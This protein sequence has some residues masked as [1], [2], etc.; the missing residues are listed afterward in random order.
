MLSSWFSKS[1]SGL[2]LS[3]S[4]WSRPELKWI[5]QQFFPSRHFTLSFI[6]D[7]C[8][9]CLVIIPY[10]T[11]SHCIGWCNNYE[12]F[13]VLEV[14]T[15]KDLRAIED[16]LLHSAQ[17]CDHN[18][19]KVQSARLPVVSMEESFRTSFYTSGEGRMQNVI[20][21]F[22]G[23]AKE[24]EM[25]VSPSSHLKL[26]AVLTASQNDNLERFTKL[27]EIKLSATKRKFQRPCYLDQLDM[28]FC[29]KED[30][31]VIR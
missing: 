11:L 26:N 13:E 10:K 15:E 14:Q 7:L 16:L 28:T 20:C 8:S 22:V 1:L 4:L 21:Q 24:N 3:I 5:F 12:K 30:K 25:S 17:R 2:W 29:R 27:L 19:F 9:G 23:A 31:S 6:F 18:R